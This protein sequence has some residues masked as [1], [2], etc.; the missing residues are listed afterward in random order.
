[1]G[2]IETALAAIAKKVFDDALEQGKNTVV[3]WARDKVGLEPRK[4]AFKRALD[5]AY[6]E[7]ETRYPEWAHDLFNASFF[8]NEGAPILA[9]FLL[10]D[11][12]PDPTE[13]ATCGSDSL[14]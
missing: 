8:E 14:N 13:L 12:H 1:M 6:R 5:N 4:Q 2:L 9:Q 11:G 3:A 10:R 7:F